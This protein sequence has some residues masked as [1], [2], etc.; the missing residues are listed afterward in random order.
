MPEVPIAGRNF[1]EVIE[2]RTLS[3]TCMVYGYP[4]PL[5]K[6]SLLNKDGKVDNGQETSNERR[7]FTLRRRLRFHNVRRTVTKIQC[8]MNGGYWAGRNR[9]W[10]H[11]VVDCKYS[12]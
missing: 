10:R 11:V 7:N 1:L 12:I 5:L 6:C 4:V 2:G 9:H 8:Q 3:T